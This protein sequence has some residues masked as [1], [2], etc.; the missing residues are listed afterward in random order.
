MFQLA[1]RCEVRR[2]PTGNVSLTLNDAAGPSY[3]AHFPPFLG[4]IER[5]ARTSS[6]D[7]CHDV[8]GVTYIMLQHRWQ[9]YQKVGR[10]GS[11][12]LPSFLPSF[13]EG[14]AWVMGLQ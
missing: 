13:S 5:F 1:A 2:V 6:V 3:F 12:F 14:C 4:K 10:E 7:A 11:P 8:T 9:L